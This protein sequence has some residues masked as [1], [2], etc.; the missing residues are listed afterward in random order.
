M[1]EN[2][3]LHC[4]CIKIYR[5]GILLG[6]LVTLVYLAIRVGTYVLQGKPIPNIAGSWQDSLSV[7][8]HELVLV[9]GGGLAL[10]LGVILTRAL[11]WD[12]AKR[13]AYW[14]YAGLSFLLCAVGGYFLTLPYGY[15]RAG[16]DLPAETLPT[17]FCL[18][19]VIYLFSAWAS[20]GIPLNYT[21]ID[22]PRKGYWGRVWATAGIMTAAMGA[23]AVFAVLWYDRKGWQLIA[24]RLN[25]LISQDVADAVADAFVTNLVVTILSLVLAYILLSWVVKRAYD[26]PSPRLVGKGE[27]LIL[28]AALVTGLLAP[29]VNVWVNLTLQKDALQ[30]LNIELG[31]RVISMTLEQLV[32]LNTRV[33]NLHTLV[34]AVLLCG[35]LGKLSHSR[36]ARVAIR[37]FLTLQIVETALNIVRTVA[38]NLT[39]NSTSLPWDE[40]MAF[41][42]RLSVFMTVAAWLSKAVIVAFLCVLVVSLRRHARCPGVAVLLPVLQ[43]VDTVLLLPMALVLIRSGTALYW[44]MQGVF[45][46]TIS[47]V[48]FVCLLLCRQ[49]DGTEGEVTPPVDEPMRPED[50]LMEI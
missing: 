24:G 43:G 37:G 38:W 30:A 21:F 36:G 44:I 10:L 25:T 50:Y 34:A 33:A 42:S 12:E 40:R 4:D 23:V 17:L 27:T 8:L 20:R 39:L 35:L 16:S 9:L 6:T 15:L 1:M 49:P 13:H 46:A 28:T 41:Y 18:L 14:R 47:I 26:H 32:S 19:T 3:N 31:N 48:G 2:E 11:G 29:A 22:R 7:F 45:S 5:R